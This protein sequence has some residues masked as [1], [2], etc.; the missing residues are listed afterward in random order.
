MTVGN[1]VVAAVSIDVD[2]VSS[3]ASEEAS[4]GTTAVLVLGIGV[5]RIATN[6]GDTGVACVIRQGEPAVHIGATA[7]TVAAAAAVA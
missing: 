1:V 7:P 5:M 6:I 3:S 2:A 4:T